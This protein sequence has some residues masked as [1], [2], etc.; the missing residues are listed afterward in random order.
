M[1]SSTSSVRLRGRLCHHG[2]LLRLLSEH[3]GRVFRLGEQQ[4][5]ATLTLALLYGD[6][7]ASG[8][9]NGRGGIRAD[10]FRASVMR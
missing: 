7:K 9:R 1:A 8:F 5:R 4:S 2:L 3:Q 10:M 6:R